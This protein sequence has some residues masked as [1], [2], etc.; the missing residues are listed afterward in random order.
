MASRPIP[1]S[2]ALSAAADRQRA[3]IDAL[4]LQ[5]AHSL[6]GSGATAQQAQEV[7]ADRTPEELQLIR[8]AAARLG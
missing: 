8:D 1:T 5:T 4:T 2:E 3:G 7:A 6:H